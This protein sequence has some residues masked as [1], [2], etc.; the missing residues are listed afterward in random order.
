[1]KTFSILNTRFISHLILGLVSALTRGFLSYIKDILRNH[2]VYFP[3][4]LQYSSL[5]SSS[6]AIDP[7][8]LNFMYGHPS[9]HY[10]VEVGFKFK[11]FMQPC[12]I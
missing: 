8:I 3:L 7:S 6:Y 2:K 4:L 9:Q 11:V 5:L 1:L 12:Q 10:V